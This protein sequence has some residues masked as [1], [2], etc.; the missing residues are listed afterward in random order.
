MKNVIETNPRSFNI[1]INSSIY[2]LLVCQKACYALM[3]YMSCKIDHVGNG[4]LI[5]I[6]VANECDKTLDDLKHL[7]LDELLDYALREKISEKTELVRNLILSNAFSNT[8]LVE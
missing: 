2:S 3:N 4:F 8:G 7:L 6:N 5:E 1:E